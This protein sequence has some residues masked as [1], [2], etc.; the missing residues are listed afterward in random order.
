MEE[1]YEIYAIARVP[2]FLLSAITNYLYYL[3]GRM[4]QEVINAYNI[5]YHI[6]I[7]CEFDTRFESN[8]NRN[9]LARKRLNHHR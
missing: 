9:T 2:V 5:L 3:I 8:Y 7:Q 4:N 6:A 1:L